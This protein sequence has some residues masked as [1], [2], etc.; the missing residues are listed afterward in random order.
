MM[1]PSSDTWYFVSFGL[2]ALILRSFML[3][4]PWFVLLEVGRYPSASRVPPDTIIQPL[5]YTYKHVDDTRKS[6]AGQGFLAK[7]LDS[8]R[9]RQKVAISSERSGIC[10]QRRSKAAAGESASACICMGG[11]P[12]MA[13]LAENRRM[14]PGWMPSQ[15]VS[16]PAEFKARPRSCPSIYPAHGNAPIIKPSRSCAV[17]QTCDGHEPISIPFRVMRQS[18]DRRQ[19]AD[20]SM[21]SCA[22]TGHD[23][24][25]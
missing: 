15:P 13:G 20:R 7:N 16:I 1:T 24:C 21:D 25:D 10:S 11:L 19:P 4:S 14:N 18:S 8:E 9:H 2:R 3:L 6:K 22:F 5:L 12:T 17:H 23:T